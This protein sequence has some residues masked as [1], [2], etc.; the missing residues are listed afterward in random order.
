MTRRIIGPVTAASI[1]QLLS[2]ELDLNPVD[3]GRAVHLV[4]QAITTAVAAG[5]S[6]AIPGFGV[7]AAHETTEPTLGAVAG[8][9]DRP[10]TLPPHQQILFWPDDRLNQIVR[11][12][13][14]L[15]SIRTSA[16][17]TTGST[18]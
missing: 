9:E 12:R 8:P 5:H 11:V 13:D 17:E 1:E 10:V 7:F 16:A 14:L 6:A 18:A 3:A 4:F 2:A 15:G